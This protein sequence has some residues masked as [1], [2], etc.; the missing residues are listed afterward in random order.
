MKILLNFLF[1]T[2]FFIIGVFITSFTVIPILIII[3]FGIPHTLK[4]ERLGMLKNGNGIIRG[5]IIS[6]L[7]LSTI[8]IGAT[9]LVYRF[10]NNSFIGYAISVVFVL[11][12][13]IGK[14]GNNRN[15]LSDY[16]ETNKRH[17]KTFSQQ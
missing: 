1:L 2:I 3:F 12:F 15:N 11:V 5:Y 10:V 6:M 9:Y 4:L 16:I 8:F 14:V 7:L 13:G 17:L